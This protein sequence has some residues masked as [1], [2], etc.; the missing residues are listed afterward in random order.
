M[1]KKVLLLSLFVFLISTSVAARSFRT[2]SALKESTLRIYYFHGERRC[3][4]CISIEKN[5]KALLENK[6]KKEMEEGSIVFYS[7]D[8]SASKNKSLVEEYE[9]TYS[10]LILDT[11]ETNKDGATNLT[12][13]GFR[14]SRRQ[15]VK[16]KAALQKAID[17]LLI[18]K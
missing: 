1:K 10:S 18:K 4:T 16:F 5:T 14:Y 13:L 6:Y 3:P 7:I 8:I 2:C 9:V 12:S 15:P 11:N 17:A